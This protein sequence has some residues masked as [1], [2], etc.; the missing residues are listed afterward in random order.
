MNTSEPVSVSAWGERR[1]ET[2][3]PG[4]AIL[5]VLVAGQHVGA[6]WRDGAASRWDTC[7]T[8]WVSEWY[9]AR[10]PVAL[11]VPRQ[12][13]HAT[14]DEALR[15]V[16]HSGWARKLGARAASPVYWSDRANRLAAKPPGVTPLHRHD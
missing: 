15:A 1:G 3:P 11:T 4:P 16:L 2:R 14:A 5:R 6:F 12:V 9:P 7:P 8:S 13:Q 10:G